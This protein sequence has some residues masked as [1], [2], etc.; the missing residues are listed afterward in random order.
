MNLH[1]GRRQSLSRLLVCQLYHKN[2]LTTTFQLG[3]LS[4]R[5]ETQ[6]YSALIHCPL[7]KHPIG[8]FKNIFSMKILPTSPYKGPN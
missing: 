6:V 8:F 4:Y 2:V 7:K 5:Y 3:S 1:N